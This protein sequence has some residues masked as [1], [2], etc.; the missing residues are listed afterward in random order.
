MEAFKKTS[1]VFREVTYALTGYQIDGLANGAN[2]F[3]LTPTYA[4]SG[5][6][7]LLFQR[8]DSGEMHLLA[9]PFSDQLTDLMDLHLRQQNSIPVFLAALLMD[10]FSR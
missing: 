5:N 1:Q 3:R 2:Q 6:D 8:D 10:L 4:E 7:Y 9:T